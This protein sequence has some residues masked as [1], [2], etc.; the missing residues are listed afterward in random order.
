MDR[1][2]SDSEFSQSLQKVAGPFCLLIV[3]AARKM[4]KTEILSVWVHSRSRVGTVLYRYVV[5]RKG[6]AG[7]IWF[8]EGWYRDV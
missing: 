1:L 7:L 2:D 6:D 5:C 4:L 3:T 8:D